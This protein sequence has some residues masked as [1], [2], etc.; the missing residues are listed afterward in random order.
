MNESVNE[1]QFGWKRSSGVCINSLTEEAKREP[2]NGSLSGVQGQSPSE[3]LGQ[4]PKAE[5]Q[6]VKSASLLITVSCERF[7][8]HEDEL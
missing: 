3:G 2:G 6:H 7:F 5:N 1:I 4:A 8:S